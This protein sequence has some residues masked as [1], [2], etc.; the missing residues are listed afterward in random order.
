LRRLAALE[1]QKIEDEYNEIMARIAYLEDLLA[2]PQKILMLVRDDVLALKEKYGDGRRTAIV[3]A[4]TETLRD[5]D[6]VPQEQVLITLTQRGYIKRVPATTFRKQ[7]RGGRGVTGLTKA[8]EDETQR[9]IAARTLD[10]M[11]FFTDR[12]RVYSEKVFRVP[13]TARTAKGTPLVNVIA[14]N[15]GEKVTA[16]VDIAAFDADADLLMCTQRGRIKRVALAEFESVRASGIV[17]TSLEEGDA[18]GWVALTRPSDEAIMISARG[19][20]LRFAVDSVRKMGRAAGGVSSMRLEEG[21]QIA[22]MD[23]VSPECELLIVTANGFGK[24]TPLAEFSTKGRRGKGMWA[25]NHRKIDEVGLIVT[26]QVVSPADEVTLISAQGM[27]LRTT[28]KQVSRQGRATKGTRIMRLE[29]GDAL[30][31]VACFEIEKGETPKAEAAAGAPADEAAAP[32]IEEAE[33][34]VL[35]ADEDGETGDADLDDEGDAN[36]DDESA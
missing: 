18:L 32:E 14:L 2:N 29:E 12:G 8:S 28:A 1:R 23:I 31:S 4:E 19:K 16:M 7:S 25:I 11:L 6:L 33:P 13:D 30:R 36:R 5:E 22:G 27:V 35:D 24:R 34:D 26:A 20:A 10:T 9:L 17:S 15:E 21:D 3:N